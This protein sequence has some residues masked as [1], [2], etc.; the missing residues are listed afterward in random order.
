MLH[1]VCCRWPG[2]SLASAT[3]NAGPDPPEEHL[4]MFIFED[5][6]IAVQATSTLSLHSAALC[7]PA[8]CRRGKT[9]LWLQQSPAPWPA[10]HSVVSV[11]LGLGACPEWCHSRHWCPWWIHWSSPTIYKCCLTCWSPSN[12]SG[13]WIDAQCQICPLWPTCSSRWQSPGRRLQFPGFHAAQE[14]VL[15]L[16]LNAELRVCMRGR[17]RDWLGPCN[18]R[19]GT[20]CT[21]G[22]CVSALISLPMRRTQQWQ[23]L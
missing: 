19:T 3:E 13:L 17:G 4:F 14:D 16:P 12:C 5:L 2:G 20:P 15:Y 7:V 21:V 6:S 10:H 22:F 23:C 18:R 8:P 1:G 9:Q 11:F